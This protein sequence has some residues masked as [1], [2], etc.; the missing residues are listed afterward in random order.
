MRSCLVAFGMLLLSGFALGAQSRAEPR[1][2]WR[3]DHRYWISADRR[4]TVRYRDPGEAEIL[5]ELARRVSGDKLVDGVLAQASSRVGLDGLS[6]VFRPCGTANAFYYARTDRIVLCAELL[7]DFT[8]LMRAEGNSDALGVS[9]DALR[10][11][12]AHEIGHAV[13]ARYQL[14]ITGD[15]EIAADEFAAWL[16]DQSG[17]KG[18]LINADLLFIAQ[19][20]HE[21]VTYAQ[22]VEAHGLAGQRQARLHCWVVVMPD[23]QSEDAERLGKCLSSTARAQR[24]WAT[25][26]APYRPVGAAAQ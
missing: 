1:A 4:D 5:G 14:P 22:A 20:L 19:S 10:F 23:Y 21:D 24:T 7:S 6:I 18:E 16:L 3:E 11:T 15:E 17:E 25:L 8:R 12:A 26:L 2:A 13:I 9:M